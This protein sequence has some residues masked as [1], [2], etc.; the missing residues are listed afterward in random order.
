M[1]KSLIA[2]GA[3]IASMSLNAQNYNFA[4]FAG[5][6]A[7]IRNVIWTTPPPS[8]TVISPLGSATVN[9][10]STNQI[11]QGVGR[12]DFNAVQGAQE[13]RVWTNTGNNYDN[14]FRLEASFS[15]NNT[16]SGKHMIISALTSSNLNMTYQIPMTVCDQRNILD[17]LGMQV[18]TLTPTSN[19][20]LRIAP[21]VIDN[22]VTV[23]NSISVPIN[24][25]TIYYPRIT[26]YD[27]GRALFEL[28]SNPAR[29]T[30]LFSECFDV[31]ETI[32]TLRFLQI[33][34]HSA[35][36]TSRTITGWVDDINIQEQDDNCCDI[37]LTGNNVICNQAQTTF[38]AQT[39]QTGATVNFTVQ[40]SD[41]TFTTSGNQIT[42][43][44]WGTF[45]TIPKIVTVT[46]TSICNC[47]T[48]S[49]TQEI[50][51]YPNLDGDFNLVGVTTSGSN[52]NNFNAV[53]SQTNPAF[54]HSWQVFSSDV[55]STPITQIRPTDITSGAT[56]VVN[57]SA[58]PVM[59]TNNFYLIRHIISFADGSCIPV[60]EDRLLY[61]SSNMQVIILDSDK[62]EN[63]L[64]LLSVNENESVFELFPNPT[65]GLLTLVSNK[66]FE[67]VSIYDTKGNLVK[68][69]LSKEK[70]L[71]LELNELSE[72]M[73]M[74]NATY[75]DGSQQIKR[76]VKK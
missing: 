42:F 56:Y 20:N 66:E 38:T 30:L 63:V 40:P 3:L 18:F 28:F 12:Y 53:S 46:A 29:T 37:D 39:T 33:G 73:Y 54:S 14:N 65:D 50:V 64:D 13:N 15:I 31:P 5:W 49:T 9:S 27:N 59:T 58:S 68:T 22:G 55:N 69:I 62:K 61:V 10:V 60:T 19:A 32:G 16:T 8:C 2:I 44:G 23:A 47:E 6:S 1:K 24:Y 75:S 72:G 52:I 7:N 36:G 11:L 67:S 4:T 41:V 71:K 35:A 70:V 17:L 43:T 51:V 34:Q 21:I 57:T 26:V 25:A 76:F 45:T 74:L 48:I